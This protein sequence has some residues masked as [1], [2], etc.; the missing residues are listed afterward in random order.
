MKKLLLKLI[1][2]F[3][4]L[5]C[6]SV[7]LSACA[8][9]QLSV[10]VSENGGSL[11]YEYYVNKR[12]ADEHFDGTLPIGLQAC[13]IDEV[14][15][16]LCYVYSESL[17]AQSLGELEK[18]LCDIKLYGEDGMN[19]FSSASASSRSLTLTVNP[20]V[21]DDIKDV[22]LIRGADLEALTRLTLK[23]TMSH[24][25]ERYSE[26]ALS[27]D[28]RTLTLTLSGFDAP[29]SIEIKCVEAETEATV[30]M[31]EPEPS[32]PK[33][34]RLP[35]ILSVIG[36]VSLILTVIGVAISICVFLIKRKKRK[37]AEAMPDTPI[38][39]F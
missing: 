37:R 21:T 17:T 9:G 35:F 30:P 15:G 20:F 38:D 3:A 27:D 10:T 12:L 32:E 36:V 34:S 25:I 1:P 16:E 33:P 39:K 18:K 29:K 23:V 4:A 26:G 19:I 13:E 31:P 7:L 24:E 28:K 6:T 14:N 22:A 2:L 5:L 11:C 8:D